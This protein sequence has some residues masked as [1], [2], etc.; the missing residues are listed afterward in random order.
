MEVDDMEIGDNTK[1][2]S[3]TPTKFRTF[4]RPEPIFPGRFSNLATFKFRERKTA[5]NIKR[6]TK[7]V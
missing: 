2:T 5:D 1:F 4:L 3:V 6:K 7:S